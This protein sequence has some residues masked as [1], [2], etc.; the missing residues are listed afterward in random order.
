MDITTLS[1]ASESINMPSCTSTDTSLSANTPSTILVEKFVSNRVPVG[2][3]AYAVAPGLSHT[4]SRIVMADLRTSGNVESPLVQSVVDFST[5]DV[6]ANKSITNSA[7]PGAS[8]TLSYNALTPANPSITTTTSANTTLSG[9]E[10]EN[11]RKGNGETTTNG[12]EVNS[13]TKDPARLTDAENDSGRSGSTSPTKI[14]RK[15]TAKKPSFKPVSLNKQFLKDTP[16]S[17]SSSLSPNIQSK[18][19]VG[20]GLALG[21]SRPAAPSKLR[22]IRTGGSS[23]ISRP[24]GPGSSGSGSVR[25]EPQPV[26]N[27]NKPTPQPQQKDITDEELEKKYGI[28]LASR[29]GSDDAT[30]KEA[31]WADID[32]DDDDWAPET[33]QWND[34]TKAVITVNA[35]EQISPPKPEPKPTK[36][37]DPPMV[38]PETHSKPQPKIFAGP[39]KDSK[40]KTLVTEKTGSKPVETASTTAPKPSPWKIPPAPVQPVSLKPPSQRPAQPEDVTRDPYSTEKVK[41]VVSA[42]V[43]D[44]SW[45]E[46]RGS[47]NNR[48]LFNSHTGQM[49]PVLDNR[50]RAVRSNRGDTPPTKPAVLQRPPPVT[51]MH[52]EP[53]AAFQQHRVAHRP[54]EYRRRRTSSNVSG[55]SGSIGRRQSFTRFGA[56]PPTPDDMGFAHNRPNYNNPFDESQARINLTPGPQNTSFAQHKDVSPTMTNVLPVNSGSV[57]GGSVKSSLAPLNAPPDTPPAPLENAEDIVAQQDRIMRSTR[58]SRELAR[59]QRLEEEAKE[60]AAKRA[61]LQAK[62]DALDKAAADKKAKEEEQIAIKVAREK[63]LADRLAEAKR[64]E[65]REKASATARH[66]G[67]QWEQQGQREPQWQ[68]KVP[69]NGPQESP[70]L[71]QVHPITQPTN[72]TTFNLKPISHSSHSSQQHTATTDPINP[73]L[74]HQQQQPAM[75]N[76]RPPHLR[77]LGPQVQ[78]PTPMNQPQPSTGDQ[79]N[80]WGAIG[81]RNHNGPVRN[82]NAGQFRSNG[83]FNTDSGNRNN[84]VTGSAYGNRYPRREERPNKVTERPPPSFNGRPNVN[85]SE[86]RLASNASAWSM[87]AIVDGDRKIQEDRREAARLAEEAGKSSKDPNLNENFQCIGFFQDAEVAAAEAAEERAKKMAQKAIDKI[88]RGSQK[89]AVQLAVGIPTNHPDHPVR[90]HTNSNQNARTRV[91]LPPKALRGPQNLASNSS[92]INAFD[93]VTGD[94]LGLLSKTKQTGGNNSFARTKPELERPAKEIP[95]VKLPSFSSQKEDFSTV[96]DSEQFITELHQQDFGSTPVVKLPMVHVVHPLGNNNQVVRHKPTLK[97]VTQSKEMFTMP[98]SV[99]QEGHEVIVVNLPGGLG[100][101]EILRPNKVGVKGKYPPK[102]SR[103]RSN[104]GRGGHGRKA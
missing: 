70:R 21:A 34:G 22:L 53:S 9:S 98:A 45:R 6:D 79:K 5:T 63:E 82:G 95:R 48:E 89:R 65:D 77:A 47:Q 43:Y 61:R 30:N 88:A 64:S 16:T 54:D 92:E 101:K 69:L 28:H 59:T 60:E 62:L 58:E 56:D 4:E 68:Q 31:K 27:K 83:H 66:R 55:G 3:T 76:Y 24:T 40:P 100:P 15:S 90:D 73:S 91:N 102:S 84:N 10:L 42:D 49:E 72:P 11:H 19:G 104:K 39:A 80:P 12:V 14:D 86:D 87:G 7:V 2:S 51:S 38:A 23:Q 44:R 81:E 97:P 36:V 29:L 67:L 32:E 8:K 46:R 96:P 94:I 13:D 85:I 25:A 75:V 50:N 35:E 17:V 57:D 74:T 20:P 1:A 78:N 37:P 52:P 71:S 99:N 33:I 93:R 103:G 18:G 41:E 26:W